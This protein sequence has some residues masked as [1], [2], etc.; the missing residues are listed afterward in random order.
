MH[1]L[2][3]SLLNSLLNCL[4]S[5]NCL[6]CERKLNLAKHFCAWCLPEIYCKNIDLFCKA[7]FCPISTNNDTYICTSCKTNPLPYRQIRFLWTYDFEA[8]RFINKMKYLNSEELCHYAGYLLDK[9]LPILFPNYECDL[10]IPMPSSKQSASKRL[11]YPCGIIARMLKNSLMRTKIDY[12][13]LKFKSEH[14]PQALLSDK[15]RLKNAKNSCLVNKKK[16]DN[17][18]I[19]LIEDV[20][21]TGSSIFHAS[22]ELLNAGA[23][24]VDVL[25]LARV[26]RWQIHRN[27][28]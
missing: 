7:C 27:L 22:N 5:N 20:V 1:Y 17:Q 14:K 18:R 24:S 25:A 13:A 16:V 3:D 11:Y 28:C 4:I 23:K 6:V 8:R 26:S 9:H 15:E 21:T 10:I 12:I 19:L 2:L